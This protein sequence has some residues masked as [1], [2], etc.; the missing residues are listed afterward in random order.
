MRS[1]IK[2][3]PAVL[4]LLVACSDSPT[5]AGTG[6]ATLSVLNALAPSDV[7]TAM[8][9]GAMFN[10]PSSGQSTGFP[11]SAGSHHLEARNPGGQVLASLDFSV[12]AG[13]HRTVVVAG[14]LTGSVS[15]VSALDTASI[16]PANAAKVRVVHTVPDA[17]PLNALLFLT[18]AAVDSSAAFVTPFRYR[19]GTDPE[20]PGYAVRPLGSYTV[21][22]VTPGTNATVAETQVI[23]GDGQLWSVVLVRNGA[24]AL[25]LRP[26]REGGQQLQ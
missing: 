25:E 18:G 15:I 2:L 11:V 21:R 22:V 19:T 9:D 1:P 14:S 20:F 7:A 13:K 12:A 23:L 4:L 8:L 5:T 24:G 3:V 16:P 10:L 26:V 6:D 17:P